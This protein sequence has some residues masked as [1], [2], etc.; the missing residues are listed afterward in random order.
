MKNRRLGGV[1]LAVLAT[2]AS[3]ALA[4]EQAAPQASGAAVAPKCKVALV[5]P[6]SG[7]AECVDPP[8]V[9]VDPPPPRP[10]QPCPQHL[11]GMTPQELGCVPQPAAEAPR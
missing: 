6:V 5:S 1:L 2:A 10:P 9:P 11:Q 4:E 3:A 8:G 7:N